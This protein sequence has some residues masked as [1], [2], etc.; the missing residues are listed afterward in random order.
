MIA[1]QTRA[2]AQALADGVPSEGSAVE[3]FAAANALMGVDAPLLEH[4]R[5]LALGGAGGAELVQAARTE[6]ARAF[7]RLERGHP[8]TRFAAESPRGTGRP[9]RKPLACASRWVEGV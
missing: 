1:E 8:G 4:V 9:A 7:D 6:V 2:L 5:V 3:R